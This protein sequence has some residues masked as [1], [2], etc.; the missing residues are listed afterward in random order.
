[1]SNLSVILQQMKEGGLASVSPLDL[2]HLPV[3][4]LNDF[5]SLTDTEPYRLPI[6][7]RF[8][9]LSDSTKEPEGIKDAGDKYTFRRKGDKN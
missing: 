3:R 2:S 9:L 5:F 8:T 7:F 1:M 6:W 4:A